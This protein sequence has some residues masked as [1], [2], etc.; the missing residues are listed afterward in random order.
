MKMMKKM[1][2]VLGVFLLCFLA[3]LVN[4]KEVKAATT[5]VIS[6]NTPYNFELKGNEARMYQFTAPAKGYFVVS[7][8]NA[9]ATSSDTVSASLYDGANKQISGWYSSNRIVMPQYGTGAGSSFFLKVSNNSYSR[10]I[11]LSLTVSFYQA[12]NW[13]SESNDTTSTSD[14]ISAKKAYYGNISTN[15]TCDIYKFKLKTNSKVKINFG[16]ASVDGQNYAWNVILLNSKNE[17]TG[18]YNGNTTQ[19]YTA[20]LKK[21]TYYIKVTNGYWSQNTTYKLSYS[22]STLKIKKP[23]VT[24]VSAKKVSSYFSGDHAKINSVKIKN[25]GSCMGYTVRIAKSSNMKGNLFKQNMD[26]GSYASKSKVTLNQ[27]FTYRKSFYIQVRGYV[28]DPFGGY[29]YGDY[30]KVKSKTL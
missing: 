27:T 4:T 29:I 13:E 12:D 11:P 2:A 17:T 5:E 15:D 16:P 22:A 3:A 8:A 24:S 21:G 25:S 23:Q 14:S 6:V 7:L 30:S 26:F 20:Y 1:T 9:D 28:K 19:A 18:I 10:V